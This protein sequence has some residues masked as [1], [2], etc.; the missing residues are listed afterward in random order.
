[1]LPVAMSRSSSDDNAIRY[2]LSD[3]AM[4]SHNGTNGPKSRM[5]AARRYVSSSSPGGGANQSSDNV[6]FGRVRQLA[7]SGEKS[8]IYDRIL[9]STRLT[10]ISKQQIRSSRSLVTQCGSPSS[11]RGLPSIFAYTLN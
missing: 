5:N 3:D 11:I 2:V 7:A 4:F 9:P 10:Q 1:M 6:R 8:A